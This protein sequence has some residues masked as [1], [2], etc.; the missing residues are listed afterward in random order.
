[1]VS[2]LLVGLAIGVLRNALALEPQMEAQARDAACGVAPAAPPP[3]MSA[4]SS[5]SAIPA[6]STARPGKPAPPPLPP[7]AQP[8][9]RLQLTR[10]ERGPVG[11]TFEFE[12][13]A[14]RVRVDCRREHLVLGDY[15]CQK[16]Y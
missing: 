14:T 4:T 16:T 12:N 11:R 5:S 7:P 2:L 8:P 6:P 13:G 9:C 3:A 1:V 15:A 10:W